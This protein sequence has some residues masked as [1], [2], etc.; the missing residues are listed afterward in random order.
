M[1]KR[2]VRRLAAIFVASVA[3]RQP[4]LEERIAARRGRIV[5]T[6]NDVLLAEFSSLVD[7]ADC[8][9]SVQHLDLRIGIN[10]GDVIIDGGDMFG[11]GVDIATWLA[12]LT[13][14][15]KICVS[16]IVMDQ[17]RDRR[18]FTFDDLGEHSLKDIDRPIRAYRLSS[19][20]ASPD[21]PAPQV[22]IRVPADRPSIA[23]LPFTNMTGDTGHDR[24]AEGIAQDITTALSQFAE[25]FV[26]AVDRPAQGLGVRYVL[27]GSVRRSDHQLRVTSRLIEVA[28]RRR[29]W[30]GSVDGGVDD[31]FGLQ[32]RITETVV[33]ALAPRLKQAEIE[34]SQRK[35]D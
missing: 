13:E 24:F 6:T 12:S 31:V 29:L 10:L 26:M 25:F 19:T 20:L 32:D 16:G 1:E 23:V 30:D 14:R 17:L 21:R 28:S 5:K 7:A 27:E 33:G 11:D 35:A 34:R 3:D 4:V 22:P 15:D 9:C 8:A 18:G 2:K